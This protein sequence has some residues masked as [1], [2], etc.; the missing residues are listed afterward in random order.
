MRTLLAL[1]FFALISYW[2]PGDMLLVA[3][4]GSQLFSNSGILLLFFLR[5]V[6]LF[7]NS[8]GR[9]YHFFGAWQTWL[10]AMDIYLLCCPRLISA[11]PLIF[12]LMANLLL[13]TIIWVD[14]FR[15]KKQKNKL[16]V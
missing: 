9:L 8:S 1:G 2:I 12:L 11:T 4:A 7:K 6:K 13:G 3:F 16:S 10:V 14:I 5:A 15:Q